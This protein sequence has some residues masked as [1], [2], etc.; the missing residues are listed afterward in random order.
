MPC[1]MTE[2]IIFLGPFTFE[3]GFGFTVIKLLPP[4]SPQRISALMPHHRRRT[5]AQSP[6]PRLQAPACVN[7]ITRDAELC[8]EPA[9]RAQ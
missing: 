8:V 6:T 2:G 9:C 3:H 7:I 4:V 5:K 1:D